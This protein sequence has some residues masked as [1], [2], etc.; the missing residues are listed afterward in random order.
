MLK[1]I[2]APLAVA[3][4]ETAAGIASVIVEVTFQKSQKLRQGLT[5]QG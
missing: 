2:I 1:T 3:L 5:E 4:P